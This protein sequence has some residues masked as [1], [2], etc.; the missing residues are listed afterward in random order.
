MGRSQEA[1]FGGIKR[2]R[3]RFPFAFKEIHSDNGTEFINWHL[4]R[5]TNKEI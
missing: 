2:V 4:F 1:V 5:Y 3:N